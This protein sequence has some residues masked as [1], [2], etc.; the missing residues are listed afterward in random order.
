MKLVL[1]SLALVFIP[2]SAP[3][4]ICSLDP[5]P[6]DSRHEFQF[7]AGYSPASATLIGATVDRRF[8]AAG[9]FYSYRCGAW[10]HTSLSFTAGAMPVATLLQPTYYGMPAHAVYGFGITPIG[11]TFDVARTRTLY[12]FFQADGGIIA[13]TERI[14]VNVTDATALNFLFDFGGG[15]KW[16][17][18]QR[19]YGLEFGY[20]FLHISNGFTTPVNPGVDNNLFF[21]GVELFR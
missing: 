12:P 14:P 11:L 6:G 8:I 2:V 16:H 17:P 1:A 19:R 20:K 10:P 9:L 4:G 18:R 3:A 21:A 13:S 5:A 15:L 7:F